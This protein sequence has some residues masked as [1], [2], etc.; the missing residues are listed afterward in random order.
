MKCESCGM[1]VKTG[2]YCEHCVDE[3]GNLETLEVRLGK[4]AKA[5]KSQIPELT[6][7]EALEEATE[8]MREM[9]AWKGKL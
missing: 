1:P 6:E 5:F 3:N 7:E 4:M 8:Y 9:P 2:K